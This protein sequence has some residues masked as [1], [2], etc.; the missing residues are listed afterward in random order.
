[1]TFQ[2]NSYHSYHSA[3]NL[4]GSGQNQWGRVKY[5]LSVDSNWTP[6]VLIIYSVGIGLLI[7][8]KSHDGPKN[9]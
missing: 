8:T 5:S 1:M 2:P 4:P 7:K 6:A 9:K 3:Q